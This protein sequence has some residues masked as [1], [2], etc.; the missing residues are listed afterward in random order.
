[1][2]NEFLS[3]IGFILLNLLFS[4]VFSELIQSLLNSFGHIN[5]LIYW[6]IFE[7]LS[8]YKIYI[9]MCIKCTVM[10]VNII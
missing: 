8:I 7:K 6:Q 9:M 10:L 4:Y 1:M 5:L 3:L 2:F